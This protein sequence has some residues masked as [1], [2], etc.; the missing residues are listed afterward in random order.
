M[1]HRGYIVAATGYPGLRTAGPHPYLVSVSEGRA[2]LDS[3][4]AARNLAQDEAQKRFAV[5][6][7]SQGGQAVL[8]AA[9]IAKSY[10][11]ELELAGVAAAAPATRMASA[12]CARRKRIICRVQTTSTS[13]PRTFRP[14][15]CWKYLPRLYGQSKR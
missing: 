13:R 11:P 15:R 10:A 9:V 14:D 3:V 7:H 1:V 12:S 5:W 4:R 8:Y 6:G 2:V